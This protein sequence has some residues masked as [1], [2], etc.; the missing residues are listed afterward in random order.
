MFVNSALTI[1]PIPVILMRSASNPVTD[2]SFETVSDVT[3]ATPL[4]YKSVAPIP[5]LTCKV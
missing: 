1:V 4:T 3:V 5:P 2:M